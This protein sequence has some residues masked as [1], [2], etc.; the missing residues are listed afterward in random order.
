M[1]ED[2]TQEVGVDPGSQPDYLTWLPV[3]F[4]GFEPLNAL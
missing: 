1:A 4:A 3:K 2:L